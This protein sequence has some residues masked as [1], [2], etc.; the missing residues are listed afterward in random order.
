MVFAVQNV[1]ED[2]PFSRVDLISCRNLLIYFNRDVQRRVLEIFHY[3]LRAGGR[4]FLGK[5]ESIELHKD[6]FADLDKRA[7]IFLRRDAQTSTYAAVP[8]RSRR[9][10]KDTED[11]PRRGP[12]F[13][14]VNYR[15]LTAL[16]ERYCPPC[17]VINDND[18]PLHFV[19]ELR[20]FLHFP[21]GSAEHKVFDMVP[22]E[23]RGEIRA[24]VHRCRRERQVQTGTV[25]SVTVGES[26]RSFVAV[27]TPLPIDKQTMLALSFEPAEKPLHAATE[28]SGK[29]D[30][31][32]SVIIE[33]LEKELAS[34]RQHLQTVVEELETSNEELMSQSE[35]LQS[36][37]EE[38]Q[39]T[40]EE[41]Q[42]SNEELQS[43]NEELLTVND[44]LQSKSQELAGL[45]ADLQNM[46]ESLDF[47]M[48]VT[49][50][51]MHLRYFNRSADKV[52]PKEGLQIDISLASIDWH[53]DMVGLL[54]HI[55]TVIRSGKPVETTVKDD[56]GRIFTVRIMPTSAP[57]SETHGS[58]ITF[59]DNSERAAAEQD[60]REREGQYRVSFEASVMGLALLKR[61]L[62]FVRVNPAICTLL[63]KSESELLKMSLIEAMHDPGNREWRMAIDELVHAERKSMSELVNLKR[64]DGSVL[65]VLLSAG[66]VG[67]EGPI[68]AA[69]GISVQLIDVSKAIKG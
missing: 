44:E 48:L 69:Q 2:P 57:E 40:N 43:T 15:L 59:I 12:E 23:W 13:P 21:R 51:R 50:D 14:N 20:P 61:N 10:P 58:V 3:A 46:K 49:D 24:L 63:Q 35:E 60:L 39:S 36:A 33:E 37:N 54:S 6:L 5:S 22:D 9:N 45:A 47:P 65:K 11:V 17:V 55:K 26:L 7:R 30:D 68:P 32:D 52:L 34:T 67:G 56:Q 64:A 38:L 18:E 31:R 29:R 42:T 8:M 27:V 25:L 19:G 62:Q 53:I 1:I 4:L 66:L 28:A 41:L 16:S